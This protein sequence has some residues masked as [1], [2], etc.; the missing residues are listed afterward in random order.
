MPQAT[1]QANFRG[2]QCPAKRASVSGGDDATHR[3]GGAVGGCVLARESA[4]GPPS[5]G[6]AP[7]R[8]PLPWSRAAPSPAP[9]ASPPPCFLR[10]KTQPRTYPKILRVIC[11]SSALSSLKTQPRT[12]YSSRE[13]REVLNCLRRFPGGRSI[14]DR[15]LSHLNFHFC[16]L[17]SLG[18]FVNFQ[19]RTLCVSA[20][21][22]S[23]R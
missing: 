20:S 21:L 9:S 15:E 12:V 13:V 7:R 5:A 2:I 23:L 17:C 18:V 6:A 16:H 8:H 19:P 22:L 4:R 14:G 3:R 1:G 11:V 10:V